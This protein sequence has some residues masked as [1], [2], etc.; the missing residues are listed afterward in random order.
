M[1]L[2]HKT[3]LKGHKKQIIIIIHKLQLNNYKNETERLRMK[4]KQVL[5]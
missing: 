5:K 3:K 1:S 2:D 4:S